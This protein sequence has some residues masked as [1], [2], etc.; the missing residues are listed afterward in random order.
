MDFFRSDKFAARVEALMKKYHVPG[1]A[2]AL[3]HNDTVESAG[4]GLASIDPPIA[5]TPDTLLD[6]ASASKSLT[7]ASIGLLINDDKYPDIKYETPVS[8]L[9][10][11][12][13]VVQ[14]DG[15]TEAITIEDILSHRTGIPG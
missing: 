9:L 11:D 13:F 10:P 12:D 5:M 3:V 8:T 6:I 2:V 1:V 14:G 4:F 7:A 15:Y